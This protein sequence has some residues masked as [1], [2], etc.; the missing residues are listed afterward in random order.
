[1]ILDENYK[2]ELEKAALLPEYIQ[3]SEGDEESEV[4]VF[5]F[6]TMIPFWRVVIFATL[7]E[8]MM[9]EAIMKEVLSAQ[10]PDYFNERLDAEQLYRA[11]CMVDKDCLRYI[12]DKLEGADSVYNRLLNSI[13]DNN[14]AGFNEIINDGVTDTRPIVKIC[15]CLRLLYEF[16]DIVD[17]LNKNFKQLEEAENSSDDD[18]ERLFGVYFDKVLYK[19]KTVLSGVDY[20]DETHK[21]INKIF[22]TLKDF[23][24]DLLKN[25]DTEV[26]PQKAIINE[27]NNGLAEFKLPPLSQDYVTIF[28][29]IML[30]MYFYMRD[31]SELKTSSYTLEVLSGI[32]LTPQQKDIWSKYDTS[33]NAHK[34]FESDLE[35]MMEKLVPQQDP[36]SQSAE[37]PNEIEASQTEY[38]QALGVITSIIDN[39]EEQI[40]KSYD[41]EKLVSI[42]RTILLDGSPDYQ[43]MRE[44]IVYKTGKATV[45]NKVNITHLCYI[46]GYLMY[47]KVF[48]DDPTALAKLIN[49]VVDPRCSQTEKN[50]RSYI[51][52]SK[53]GEKLNPGQKTV[54][55]NVL[56]KSA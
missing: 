29:G 26:S 54:L 7:H 2:K 1:M 9:F 17:E 5:I 22:K 50:M 43:K 12:L 38:E 27:V 15:N 37:H 3:S 41:K 14:E 39:I 20:T 46:F 51:Q 40:Q 35:Q 23:V 24:D 4:E 55:D 34:E 33:D 18:F 45:Y 8:K 25:I 6:K 16:Y 42:F 49:E 19:A 53:D 48:K 10:M 30:Y 36:T 47:K 13:N 32:I 11:L 31:G 21:V 44:Y 52:K 28:Y 56:S